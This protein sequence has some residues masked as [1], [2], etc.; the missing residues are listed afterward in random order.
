MV[1]H[2]SLS[3]V[4][5]VE[6]RHYN[7]Q[8][9]V[10]TWAPILPTRVYIKRYRWRFWNV[11]RARECVTT[12]LAEQIQKYIDKLHIVHPSLCWPYSKH[13]SDSYR[14]LVSLLSTCLTIQVIKFNT[15]IM[16]IIMTNE[17]RHCMHGKK[18]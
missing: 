3:P 8:T 9:D 15:K 10:R 5:G 14:R 6:G 18:L 7:V 17:R 2:F 12:D 13:D 11:S 4:S 1:T 16:M